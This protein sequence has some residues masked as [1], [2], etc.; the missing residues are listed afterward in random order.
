[1]ISYCP[2]QTGVN[3]DGPL[4]VDLARNLATKLASDQLV[5]FVGSGI[6]YQAIAKDGSS[7]RM[8]LWQE[9]VEKVARANNENLNNYGGNLLDLFDGICSTHPPRKRRVRA[10]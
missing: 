9:L 4:K 3:M 2:L 8:P 7:A 1:M 10:R 6:S 5:I